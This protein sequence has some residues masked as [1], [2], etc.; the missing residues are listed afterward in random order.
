MQGLVT[1]SGEVA[2][3]KQLNTPNLPLSHMQR[4]LFRVSVWL[5]LQGF[6][7]KTWWFN[8]AEFVED[9]P[10]S[11]QRTDSTVNLKNNFQVIETKNMSIIFCLRKDP[12]NPTN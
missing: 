8:M 12:L 4:V 5:F 9:Y 1:S 11:L 6:C 10:L 7:R 2:D 3:C